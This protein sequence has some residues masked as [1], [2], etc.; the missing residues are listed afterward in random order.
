M[1]LKLKYDRNGRHA[2]RLPGSLSCVRMDDA[3]LMRDATLITFSEFLSRVWMIAI[4]AR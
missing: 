3:F 1:S 2:W 4:A